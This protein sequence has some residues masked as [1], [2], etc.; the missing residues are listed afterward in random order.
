MNKDIGFVIGFVGLLILL[1]IGA[2]Q[3]GGSLGNSATS[4]TGGTVTPLP[5]AVYEEPQGWGPLGNGSGT[6]QTP[7]PP[8]PR[9]TDEE[10][11]RRLVSLYRELD[12][13]S[14]E[15]R[16][17]KLREPI[18]PYVGLVR[19]NIGN[20]RDTEH[21]REY[22]TIRA[23]SQNTAPL[24]ISDWYVESYVTEERAGIPQGDR[25]IER[26]RS[27]ASD[28]IYLLPGEEAYLMTGDSPIDASFHENVCTGY[29][30]SKEDFYPSLASYCPAPLDE[31]KRFAKIDL[32]NDSCYDFVERIRYCEIVDDDVLDD[33]DL[34]NSCNRFIL[35]N[36]DYNQCVANHRYDP[37]FDNVGLWRIYFERRDELWRTE[38]EILRLMDENDRVIDVV[39][40]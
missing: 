7:P 17:T 20:A 4:T 13:L 18:S 8:S 6:T 12:T 34:T 22:L 39:E 35:E 16:E 21:E 23:D 5:D 29:L 1:A 37:L 33:A 24:N 26:W 11:E 10:I 15:L 38:R 19:L 2:A 36:L 31:M 9:L 28:D 27:P 30:E 3:N 40:Y 32:D 14:E 25:I